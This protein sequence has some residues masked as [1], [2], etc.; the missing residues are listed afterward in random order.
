M[1]DKF[2][3]HNIFQEVGSSFSPN[4]NC[5]SAEEWQRYY[6]N[7]VDDELKLQMTIHLSNCEDCMEK[8]LNRA[9]I[10]SFQAPHYIS[11]NVIRRLSEI[12][13]RSRR[14]ILIAYMSAACITLLLSSFGA[15]NK[16]AEW[17]SKFNS[18][19]NSFKNTTD[20]AANYMSDNLF[21]RNSNE[22]KK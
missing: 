21:R 15:F 2:S 3:Q 11:K 6:R 10:E 14:S 1:I 4:E 9:E 12:K 7:L 20:N 17:S 5:F 13:T 19:L 18:A 16:T 8:Y 22:T